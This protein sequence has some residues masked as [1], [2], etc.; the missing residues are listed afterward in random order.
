MKEVLR[1]NKGLFE[2]RSVKGASQDGV[3]I[4]QLIHR[5]DVH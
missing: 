3:P 2:F 4:I 5:L 1:E